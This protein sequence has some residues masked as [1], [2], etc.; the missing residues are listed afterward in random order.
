[1]FILFVARCIYPWLGSQRWYEPDSTLSSEEAVACAS[2][3]YFFSLS[4]VK[5]GF[6]L[7]RN[8]NM[9][10]RQFWTTSFQYALLVTAALAPKLIH[11]WT[12]RASLPPVI[13]ILYLPTFMGLDVINAI[14]F[15][16]LV[17]LGQVR[18]PIW[19]KIVRGIIRFVP[20]RTI[21]TSTLLLILREV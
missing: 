21:G 20:H 17:H 12:H 16:I 3:I 7:S 15:W 13:T 6:H 14:V 1:M 19:L 4:I 18:T 9:G 2:F 10:V 11:L 5:M 8:L